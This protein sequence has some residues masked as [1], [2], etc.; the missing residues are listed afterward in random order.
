M[1][2]GITNRHLTFCLPT[3]IC[4]NPS[5]LLCGFI[6]L[7]TPG[8][9]ITQPIIEDNRNHFSRSWLSV[10]RHGRAS[11][12]HFPKDIFLLFPFMSKISAV[13]TFFPIERNLEDWDKKEEP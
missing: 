13:V 10:R 11:I 9:T 3:Y 8:E 7:Q 12:F 4:D 5:L 2:L 6:A 1:R